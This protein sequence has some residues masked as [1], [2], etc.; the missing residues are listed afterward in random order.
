MWTDR[1]QYE[2]NN[3]RY[4]SDL[5]TAQSILEVSPPH[6]QIQVHSVNPQTLPNTERAKVDDF[7]AVRDTKT[8]PLPW[9]SI[10]PP[11]TVGDYGQNPDRRVGFTSVS[12]TLERYTWYLHRTIQN[13]LDNE[14]WKFPWNGVSKSASLPLKS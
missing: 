12:I 9:P 11:I 6:L 8:T 1:K 5:P 4:A 7:Y 2:R 13:V 10:A 14:R 3:G